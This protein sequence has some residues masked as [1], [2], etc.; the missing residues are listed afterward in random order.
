MVR[1]SAGVTAP[2]GAA[3]VIAATVAVLEG[4]PSNLLS[5]SDDFA[6]RRVMN[7]GQIANLSQGQTGMLSFF[8]D[9]ASCSVSAGGLSQKLFLNRLHG[10]G[11]SFARGIVGHRGS[12]ALS[13]SP[14]LAPSSPT[15][16]L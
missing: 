5:A 7:A 11:G 8:K 3:Y 1:P 12:L 15:L 16:L 2:P 9:L 14:F 13:E 6:D 10:V 4:P